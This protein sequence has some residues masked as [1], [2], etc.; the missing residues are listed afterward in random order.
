MKPQVPLLLAL[1]PQKPTL[2][3][4]PLHATKLLQPQKLLLQES[5]LLKSEPPAHKL[6]LKELELKP[7]KLLE[8]EMLLPLKLLLHS[9]KLMLAQ[10]QKH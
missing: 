2:P 1:E 7:Q 4:P 10:K 3:L 9:T 6:M 5:E 8:L